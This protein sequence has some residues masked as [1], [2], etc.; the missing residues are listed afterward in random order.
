MNIRAVRHFL[1]SGT[2]RTKVQQL[3]QSAVLVA[4]S[5]IVLL[6]FAY[7]DRHDTIKRHFLEENKRQ[8]ALLTGTIA[9]LIAACAFNA[10]FIIQHIT[11]RLTRLAT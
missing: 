5:G 3:I 4:A 8:Y 11:Q 1:L 7:I 9:L 6:T 10:R 2:P